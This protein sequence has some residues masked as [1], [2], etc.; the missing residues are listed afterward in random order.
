MRALPREY[1]I[2]QKALPAY[3][4]APAHGT[5]SRLRLAPC[6]AAIFCVLAATAQTHAQTVSLPVF[7]P[8]TC[9]GLV[10]STNVSGGSVV[11]LAGD[12]TQVTRGET[13]TA[14]AITL[15]D[16]LDRGQVVTGGQFA[17]PNNPASLV[18]NI[19]NSE[20]ISIPDPITGGSRTVEVYNNANIVDTFATSVRNQYAVTANI[21]VNG[22]QYIGTRIGT[23]DATGG[24]LNVNLGNGGAT[25]AAVNQIAM[26]AKNASLF[27]ADGTGSA[28]S[29]IVWQ[30]SNRVDMGPTASAVINNSS[31]ST[32]NFSF[33]TYAG[34]FSAFDGSSQT[35][36]SAA[37][38]QSY[39]TFLI[40]KLE[41]GALQPG[42]YDAQ[43]KRAY[44]NAYGSITF[45][46]G[47]ADLNDE[48]FVP[49]GTRVVIHANGANATGTIAAGARLD[50]LPVSRDGR[51]AN[52]Y[53]GTVM[54]GENGA[55]IIND[56][57]LSSARGG[58]SDVQYG[59]IA[60]GAR[61]TN[62]GVLNAGFMAGGA[63]NPNP[64]LP[65]YN[66]G[67]HMGMWAYWVGSTLV[68]NG[69]IN[70]LNP[71]SNALI[72]KQGASGTNNGFI[73]LNVGTAP[74]AGAGT[75]SLGVDL[76]VASTFTNAAG[77]TIYMGR[78][79]QYNV[80]DTPPD[81][82][83]GS[84]RIIGIY[85]TGFGSAGGIGSA[86]N[87][88]IITLGTQTQGS[89]GIYAVASNMPI[90]NAASG[91]I[92]VNG[93]LA[94]APAENVGILAVNTLGV[95]NAGT[96]NVNGIN[97][98][99][100]KLTDIVLP[101]VA[102]HDDMAEPDPLS[103]VA[104]NVA[105]TSSGT[106]NVAGTKSASGLR[107]YGIWAQGANSVAT[108]SG[109]VNLSGVGGIGVHARD[110][111]KIS[112]TNS[113]GVNFANGSDQ[114][115]YFIYG[116]GS[117]IT[118]AS[119]GTQD[120]STPQSTLF[121]IEA[122][123]EF[124]G[125]TGGS[126]FTASGDGATL[127]TISG[128]DAASAARS[129]YESG[130]SALTVTGTN[131][132]GVFINGGA[133]GVLTADAVIR[134]LGIGSSAGTV[135]GLRYDLNGAAQGVPDPSTLL[136][137]NAVVNSATPQLVGFVTQNQGRLL[138][139]GSMTLSG[140][141]SIGVLARAEGVLENAAAGSILVT[142]GTGVRVE[143]AGAQ[144]SNAGSIRAEDGV[145]ALQLA[146]GAG[147]LLSGNGQIQFGGSADGIR[148]EAGSYGLTTDGITI[149]AIDTLGGPA[150]SGAGINNVGEIGNILL[151]ATT[152]NIGSGIGI[153]TATNLASSSTATINVSAG[154]TGIALQNADGSTASGNLLL[155]SGLGVAVSGAGGTGI[156][157]NTAGSLDSS[158]N[159]TILDADGGA[160]WVAGLP[161]ASINRGTLVSASSAAPVVDL[162]TGSGT[163]FSN[164]GTV[165]AVSVQGSA[166]RGSASADT[167]RMAG[168]S[169]RG[170]V[171][172][173][174]GGD[175][176]LWTAGSLEGS[177]EMGAGDDAL[178]LSG[179]NL[180]TT[181]HLD[182]GDGAGDVLTLAGINW[183][184]GSLG[185]D[186]LSRGV[187]LGEAWETI[188]LTG[189]T[190]FALTDDLVFGGSTLNIDPGSTLFAGGGV[191]PI[192]RDIS[193]GVVTVHNGGNID[194]TNGNTGPTDT[195]TIQG[196]YVGE[197]GLLRL[198]TLIN[199]G[200][201]NSTSDL[202]RTQ[203]STVGA[204]P[205]AVEVVYA[206][207]TGA[208]TVGNGIL[209][210]DVAGASQADAFAL[211]NRVIGG[212]YEYLLFQGGLAAAG[213]NPDDGNWYLRNVTDEPLPPPGPG[214]DPDPDPDPD[215]PTPPPP[216]PEPQPPA[217]PILRPEVGV[218]LANQLAAS[219]MFLHTLH[220]RVGEPDYSERQREDG[221]PR[222][223]AAWFRVQRNQF[224]ASTGM[225]GQVETDADTNLYQFGAE[226]GRWG[227]GDTRLHYGAMA[228][229]GNTRTTADSRIS[230]YHAEGEVDGYALGLYATLYNTAAQAT[231]WYVDS[232]LQYADYRQR[233]FGLPLP[234][235]QMDA[236]E[237]VASIEGGYA[238]ELGATR[239]S[240]WYIEPQAQAIYLDYDSDHH[241]EVNGTD[242]RSASRRGWLTRLGGR[243]YSRPAGSTFNRV[244]PFVEVNWWHAERPSS[245]TLNEASFALDISR[246]TYELKIGAEAELGGGWTGWGHMSLQD[247]GASRTDVQGLLGVRYRW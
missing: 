109:A 106:I 205:T 140:A 133:T 119:T 150:G 141:G 76:D 36:N 216:E 206:N 126:S 176:L 239:S 69:I 128:V 120:V 170:V 200:G 131:A 14:G 21:A 245:V 208:L 42:Q 212:P 44:S 101:T 25:D 118:N 15:P 10:C 196:D 156:L 125:G 8:I 188:T 197:G 227:D 58:G 13:G 221:D 63:A 77:A 158:A 85:T 144:I 107:N 78:G 203:T 173:G 56:G 51:S 112:I 199:E 241:V 166:V 55:N 9:D 204:G 202:L 59:M 214:P 191:N 236:K 104:A 233:V 72:I 80:G 219:G 68:N 164:L 139:S 193:G 231:G 96:I 243:I 113:G 159:V 145:A 187:N 86:T 91:V 225:L 246:E 20:S 116:P 24:T 153:R 61:A 234:R 137:S 45:L 162:S 217:I 40:Q 54:L 215:P 149:D 75:K 151:D 174:D 175:A 82:P 247:R 93:A 16:L 90:S 189:A 181:Y 135:D 220:D 41:S 47:P 2:G 210:V 147:A 244:Q 229:Y 62:N 60:R 224:G 98:V 53:V 100:L 160:A 157:A 184:G 84:S 65:S 57:M 32:Q 180:G 4:N 134:L 177:L 201:P 35:V 23:V 89:V 39:N 111:G 121:R 102:D 167:V 122:G 87:A 155:G 6:A 30:S 190:Q 182:G 27:Y 97:G 172:T 179:V 237:W 114:I 52:S 168:G 146:N 209:L 99:G 171:G 194:L 19:G 110:L 17:D 43:F 74:I 79:A 138:Q 38:L 143:G 31:T 12:G 1:V 152:L 165:N 198:D 124:L 218:Y 127:F 88:G 240:N 105:V 33:S 11:T 230:G 95:S 94:G 73:N 242:I 136:T 235:E 186:D 129:R 83:N 132:R 49:I 81:T 142:N 67:G 117:A 207:N 161:L 163:D 232:W 64:I 28:A 183:R 148:V 223:R 7:T 213:G 37:A 18:V 48:V 29:N 66:L 211:S 222:I 50:A 123:A 46:N 92:N 226:L 195:L 185:S 154:G 178:T 26:I 238:F 192:I 228:G 34:T 130:N 22:Q 3:A 5:A 115:G 169:I 71:G 103:Q 70:V 108:L